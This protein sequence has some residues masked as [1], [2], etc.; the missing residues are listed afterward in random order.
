VLPADLRSIFAGWTLLRT[1]ETPLDAKWV[2]EEIKPERLSPSPSYHPYFAAKLPNGQIA[3]S[4]ENPVQNIL[5]TIAR[6]PA[7]GI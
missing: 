7:H 5:D 3:D 2:R 4:D 6:Q 1:E